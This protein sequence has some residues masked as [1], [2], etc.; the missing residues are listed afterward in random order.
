MPGLLGT[1]VWLV[2][3]FP[4]HPHH[5]AALRCWREEAGAEI[6]FTRVT[7]LDFC[8]CSSTPRSPPGGP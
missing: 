8:V 1:S 2:L 7:M 5:R 3:S 4:G 6:A